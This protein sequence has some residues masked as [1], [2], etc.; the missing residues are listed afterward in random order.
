M[1]KGRKNGSGQSGKGP[2]GRSIRNDPPSF[3]GTRPP[4]DPLVGKLLVSR[5]FIEEFLGKGGMGKVYQATDRSNN[6]KV[7]VKFM[8]K[9]DDDETFKR[10][11]REINNAS[12][13]NH[14]N[15]AKTMGFHMADS[16]FLVMEYVEGKT[17]NEIVVDGGTLPWQR[18]GKIAIQVCRALQEAHGKGIMHRDVKLGNIMVMENDFVKVLDFG[19]AKLLGREKEEK[20]EVTGTEGPRTVMLYG[21]AEPLTQAGHVHGTATCMAPEQVQ[22]AECDHRLDVYALGCVMYR[23]LCGSFPFM[24]ETEA[25]IM[26]KQVKEP[27]E[28]LSE[29]APHLGIPGSFEK[30][31]LHSL[32]KDKEKRFESATEFEEAMIDAMMALGADIEDIPKAPKPARPEPQDLT[33]HIIG[34]ELKASMDDAPSMDE[35]QAQEMESD[36]VGSFPE[37]EKEPPTTALDTAKRVGSKIWKGIRVTIV[38]ALVSA[39]VS[40]AT[41]TI[42]YGIRDKLPPNVRKFVV[43]VVDTAR[44]LA[45]DAIDEGK[46]IVKQADDYLSGEKT[47]YTINTWPGEA[48]VLILTD[49]R[50]RLI[51]K[52]DKRGRLEIELPEGKHVLIIRKGPDEK[53]VSVSPKKTTVN[54]TFT[55]QLESSDEPPQPE[56]EGPDELEIDMGKPKAMPPEP[57]PDLDMPL[58]EDIDSE[59]EIDDLDLDE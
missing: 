58:D 17:L 32:A 3:N 41:I 45:G 22:G 8:R 5:F 11:R 47:R 6:T 28:P 23:L 38:A 13:I 16:P 7:A 33:T 1:H 2:G 43:N 49:D 35:R 29:R 15:V 42:L 40:A 52:T 46:D 56:E 53:V 10:F 54:A 26:V 9:P 21:D 27:V 30:I 4:Q 55:E 50:E 12:R 39:F 20:R 34:E 18:V 19:L 37:Y 48:S 59:L 51:G 57:R 31:V 25:E 36:D 24:A 44:S 14:S